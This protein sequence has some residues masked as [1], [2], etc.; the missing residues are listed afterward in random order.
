MLNLLAGADART[1]RHT[2]TFKAYSHIDRGTDPPVLPGAPR[3]QLDERYSLLAYAGPVAGRRLSLFGSTS[4]RTWSNGHDPAR[5]GT[6]IGDGAA[7][8]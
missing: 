5:A 4:R 7:E 1:Q 2:P 8:W 6:S 3:R